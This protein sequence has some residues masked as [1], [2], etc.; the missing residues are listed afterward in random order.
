MKTSIILFSGLLISLSAAAQKSVLV[1]GNIVDKQSQGVPYAFVRSIGSTNAVYADSTGAF[2]I[3]ADPSSKLQVSVNNQVVKTVPANQGNITLDIDASAL[4]KASA[5]SDKGIFSVHKDAATTRFAGVISTQSKEVKGKRFV[6][7][8]WLRG[9]VVDKQDSVLSDAGYYFNYDML[10]GDMVY[11]TD[12]NNVSKIA[13]DEYKKIVLFD[14]AGKQ[15]AF[16]YVPSIDN[17][18]FVMVVADGKKYK[19]YKKMYVKFVKA[20]FQTNGIASTGNNYDEYQ[21]DDTYFLVKDGAAPLKL[22]LKKKA[23]KEAFG[24]TDDQLNKYMP[25]SNKIDDAYVDELVAKIEG[26]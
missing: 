8:N 12:K 7:E 14:N 4:P 24:L 23:L 5:G 25:S 18:H 19:V 22:N 17:S 21:E 6:S 20:T 1:K 3:K 2:S 9:Y 13:K 26:N 15:Y 16:A 11:T 10:D